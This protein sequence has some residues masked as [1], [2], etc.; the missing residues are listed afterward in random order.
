L[1]SGYSDKRM[2]AAWGG[3]YGGFMTMAVIT[4]APEYFG[5]AC[6][7]VGIVNFETFLE[8]TKDY[9]RALREVE[10]GPLTDREFLKTISPIY[11]IDRIDMPL[12][13]AHGLNDPRVPIGEAMQVAVALKKRGIDVEELY[14]PD[15]GHG[16]AKEENRLLYY[17]EL[18]KFL[19]EHLKK[20]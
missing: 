2:I 9:R 20:S 17:E 16:F 7:V 4:E 10:Y 12:M 11:K 6:D 15:E 1:D 19:E 18:A 5:A 3:S 14:F 8:G 13:L